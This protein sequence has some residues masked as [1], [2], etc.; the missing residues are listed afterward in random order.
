MPDAHT[1][2]YGN[3]IKGQS[4]PFKR[5]QTSKSTGVVTV[6]ESST[7]H[8]DGWH[9]R[10][11]PSSNPVISR[12]GV[13]WRTPSSYLRT[14]ARCKVTP[15]YRRRENSSTIT[16]EEGYPIRTDDIRTR[17][18]NHYPTNSSLAILPTHLRD[19]AI[20]ECLVKLA[21]SKVNLSVYMAESVKSAN[22]I[23]R[24]SAELF[25]GILALKR[26][27]SLKSFVGP[28]VRDIPNYYLEYKYGWKPLMGDI[29]TLYE[30]FA[31]RA[32][33]AMIFWASRFVN[34]KFDLDGP[35][36]NLVINHKINLSVTGGCKVWACPET[37]FIRA[38]TQW[39]LTNPLTLAWEVIPYSFVI[40]WALPIGNFLEAIT[41]TMG[42]SFVGGYTSLRMDGH[43]SGNR[44]NTGGFLPEE[45]SHVDW[46]IRKYQR[47]KLGS[48]PTARVYAK[49][50]F[51]TSNVLSALALWRQLHR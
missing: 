45:G 2:A 39:G 9:Q 12:Y 20:T 8:G 24:R 33:E 22:M 48:F 43:I 40:D 13:P 26:G 27:R 15:V 21:D 31:S 17:L 46:A 10:D 44:K 4:L 37:A 29:H 34:E 5:T 7:L 11:Y 30:E 16:V 6:T 28:G 41:S 35:T 23:A 18:W 1:D 19:Q 47:Q 51:S 32:P 14:V 38:A 49:S 3:S 42:L 50:P 25:R 36:D